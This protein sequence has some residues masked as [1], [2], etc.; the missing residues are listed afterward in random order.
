ME[1]LGSLTAYEITKN[2]LSSVAV[3]DFQVVGGRPEIGNFISEEL[4]TR[5]GK[6]SNINLVER[7][8]LKKVLEESALQKTGM[9]DEKTAIKLG[10]FLEADA[11]CTGT[12][13]VFRWSLRINARLIHI[14]TGRVFAVAPVVLDKNNELS[15]FRPEEDSNSASNSEGKTG[16][17]NLKE[18]LLV[19]GGFKRGYDGWKRN[20]GDITRGASQTEIIAFSQSKSGNALHIRHKGEGHIQF[21]QIVSV[22]GPDL[23]FMASFQASSNE[24]MV[25]GF[26]GSG[27][28]QIALQYFGENGGKLGETVL[29]NYVKNPF[30]DTPLIGVPRRKDDTYKTHYIE[31]PKAEFYSEYQID[32]RKEIENNLLGTDAGNIRQIAVIL[33][34]G[35]T[36][37]QAGSELWITDI[38]LK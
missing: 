36:H 33:W 7:K 27:V 11:L 24:G 5:L 20:I 2:Q 3:I 6:Y 22:P 8:F 9:I 13:T 38:E 19:N 16:K 15:I 17:Y 35:A 4:I 29:V 26:S 28:V 1:R 37:P 12:V 18:N 30:A 14:E 32:I 25:I 31:F 21:S 10:K 23:I 34:C